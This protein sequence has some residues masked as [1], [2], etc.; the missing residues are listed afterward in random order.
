MLM[1]ITAYIIFQG[2]ARCSSDLRNWNATALGSDWL[3]VQ[4][5]QDGCVL[6]TWELEGAAVYSEKNSDG[7]YFTDTFGATV[8]LSGHYIYISDPSEE[9]LKLLQG[10][11][12]CG[13]L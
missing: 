3:V 5:A 10:K 8:H 2:P 1:M 6:Q 11:G 7:I 13:G 4:Y 12:P 9:D